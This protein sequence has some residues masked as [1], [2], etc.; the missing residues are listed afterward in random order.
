VSGDLVAKLKAAAA[1][2]GRPE[3]LVLA[4]TVEIAS[5]GSVKAM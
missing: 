3:P 1:E 2:A 5:R 4:C